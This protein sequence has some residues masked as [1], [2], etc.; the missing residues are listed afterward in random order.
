MGN[1]AEYLGYEPDDHNRA[2]VEAALEYKA[3]GCEIALTKK[4]WRAR[5]MQVLRGEKPLYTA[6]RLSYKLFCACQID[7]SNFLN[8][9]VPQM[10]WPPPPLEER[11]S[12]PDL[13]P[14]N[15][16]DKNW[17]VPKQQ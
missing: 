16:R 15:W 9:G 2:M 12:A 7:V 6:E 1:L 14:M 11:R 3:C 8:A 13:R 5:G 17:Q 4:K 10:E